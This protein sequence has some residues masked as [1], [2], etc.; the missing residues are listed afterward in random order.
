MKYTIESNR[1][2]GLGRFDHVL[3]PKEGKGE[4][5]MIIEYKIAQNK[6]ELVNTAKEALQQ[7]INSQYQTKVKEY[8][9]VKKIINMGMA[10]CGKEVAMEYQ[11]DMI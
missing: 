7:I 8:Q 1:E 2:S 10:F 6:D 3:I 9:R 5:A 11:V 4:T